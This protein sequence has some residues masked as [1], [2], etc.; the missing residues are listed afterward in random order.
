VL[1][2]GGALVLAPSTS[3]NQLKLQSIK[4]E[5]RTKLSMHGEVIMGKS[6]VGVVYIMD[7]EVVPCSF[8]N[9]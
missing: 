7:C 4:D 2:L 6:Y 9:M 5:G 8:Q 3:P 1:V